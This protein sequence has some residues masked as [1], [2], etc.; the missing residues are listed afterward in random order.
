MRVR[1]NA[2]RKLGLL[3]SAKRI[4]EEEGLT[5]RRAAERLQVCHSLFVRW[6]QQRAADNDPILVMLKS[7]RKANHPGP[8]GQLKHLE[9]ALLRFI[10]EQREQGITVSI[11]G[12][13]VKAS[14]LS[15][16][17]NEKHFIAR[18]SAVKRFI[19]AHSLVYRM[20][21]HESQ[22][23]PDEVAAEASDYMGVMRQICEGPHRDWRFI[24]NMDQTP[25]YFTMNAKR[26]LET[27]GVK[28]VHVRTSTNDTKRATVAVTITG[29]GAVLPSMVIFKG[30]PNGRI[31]KKEFSDYPTTHHWKCQGNAWMDEGVMIAWVDE[32]LKPYVATAPEH[33]IP[34]LILDSYRCHMMGSVVQKIQ[35]LGVEVRHIPGG[36]TSLCQPVDVGF[37]KPFKDRMRKQWLSWMISEGIIHGTTMPPSRRDV[38]GWVVRAMEEMKREEQIIK[39]AWRKTGYE[40]FPKEGGE[41][42]IAA[43]ETNEGG[44]NEEIPGLVEASTEEDEASTEEDDAIEG[45]EEDEAMGIAIN[46]FLED[47]LPLFNNIMEGGND[48]EEEELPHYIIY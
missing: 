12:I 29:S 8:I 2:R 7:K 17:F 10:F 41:I 13:V 36:C 15:P 30:T 22:R 42:A 25:V 31:A 20:G 3:A 21:T 14:S 39:N 45:N 5:L 44:E 27:I 9:D 4:M 43:A 35:E 46:Q 24:I 6:Q 38:A 40:W 47:D 48:E 19:H 28:T 37:N 32:V 11:L 1:Y 26:T 33:I 23:K 18:T 34:L 16:E